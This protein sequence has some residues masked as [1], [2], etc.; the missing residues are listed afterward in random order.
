[1]HANHR[2]LLDHEELSVV[3]LSSKMR[4]FRVPIWV[5]IRINAISSGIDPASV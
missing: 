2:I 4:K 3:L 5:C 1:M